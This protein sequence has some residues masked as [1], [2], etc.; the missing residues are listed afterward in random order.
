[1]QEPSVG[2][3]WY[4]ASLLDLS[5]GFTTHFTFDLN[6]RYPVFPY[7]REGLL[8]GVHNDPAG[9]TAIGQRACLLVSDLI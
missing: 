7:G 6:D 4:N 8:F 9:A 2:T 1:M 5:A 3:V